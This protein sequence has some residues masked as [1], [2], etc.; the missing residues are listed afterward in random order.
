[1]L[2]IIRFVAIRHTHETCFE[3]CIL[4]QLK[5]IARILLVTHDDVTQPPLL[6]AEVIG[7]PVDLNG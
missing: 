7:A 2:H 5:V 3:A 6:I 1:M 4:S